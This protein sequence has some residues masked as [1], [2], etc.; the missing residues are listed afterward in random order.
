[1]L[2]HTCPQLVFCVTLLM[3]CAEGINAG[4]QPI[5]HYTAALHPLPLLKDLL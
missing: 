2:E 1:M 4:D 3:H 5:L